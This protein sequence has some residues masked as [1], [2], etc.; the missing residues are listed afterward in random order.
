METLDILEKVGD[1]DSFCTLEEL[2]KRA[3]E[4]SKKYDFQL[5]EIGKSELGHPIYMISAGDG[6]RNAL[7]WG[8]PHPNEPIGSMSIDFLIDYFGKDKEALRNS[9]YKWHFIYTAD[10]DGTRLNEGW[11]KGELDI[12]KYFL[13][14]FRPPAVRMIDWTFPVKYKDFEWNEPMQETKVLMKIIDEIKPDLMYPLHNSG[15]GGAYFFS[16]KAFKE[17]YYD[18]ITKLCGRLGIPLHMGEPEEDFM[19]EIKKP[20]YFHFGFKEYY[21]AQVKKGANPLETLKHGD[22]SAHYLLKVNPS[23]VVIVGEVPY[24]FD[25]TVFDTALSGITRREAWKGHIQRLHSLFDFYKKVIPQVLEKLDDKD[26]FSYLLKA[27]HRR[28]LRGVDLLEKLISSPE[29]DRQASNSEVFDCNVTGYFYIIG[30]G[31][32]QLRRAAIRAGVSE[33]LIKEIDEKMNKSID[34]IEAAS[35]WKLFPIKKMVQLQLAVLF[36]TMKQLK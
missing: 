15:F 27:E 22:N 35:D 34:D 33:S 10:P 12:K 31:Y 11:F 8:F 18:N 13:N 36:E 28:A 25:E 19:K 1:Y 7:V 16:T 21:E 14:F 4:Q 32:A 3:F 23:A 17:D 29:F 6:G 24:F 20:F 26:P 5:K 30:L 9:G 2:D